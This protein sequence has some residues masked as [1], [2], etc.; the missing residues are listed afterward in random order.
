[1]DT[2]TT[3][4]GSADQTGA[5]RVAE[6][7]ENT[8]FSWDYAKT[9][10]IALKNAWD[11][12]E[13]LK[14]RI[15]RDL[16]S[17]R[18]DSQDERDRGTLEN[19][20]VFTPVRIIDNNIRKE[21]APFIEYM[22]QPGRTAIFV[23]SEQGVDL[24]EREKEFTRVMRYKGWVS[25]FI[26]VQD[27][28]AT[29]GWD[30][31][32]VVFDETK[33]GHIGIDHVRHDELWIP[34][35]TRNIQDCE[36]VVREYMVSVV[37][38]RKLVKTAGFNEELVQKLI[39]A[40]KTTQGGVDSVTLT[41]KRICKVMFKVDGLVYVAWYSPDVLDAWLDGKPRKLYLGRKTGVADAMGN[42]TYDTEASNVYESQYPYFLLFYSETEM[43]DVFQH[44]GRCFLD[45]PKQEAA[46]SML[47]AL[48]NGTTRASNW[49]G[50]V[51]GNATGNA[52]KKVKDLEIE[53]GRIYDQPI[54]FKSLPYPDAAMVRAIEQIVRMNADDTNQVAFAVNARKDSRKSATEINASQEQQAQL[55]GVSLVMQSTFLVE[56]WTYVEGIV[57]SRALANLFPYCRVGKENDTALL[58][59]DVILRP[60]GDVDVVERKERLQA[61]SLAWPLIQNTVL[62]P[63]FLQDMLRLALPG[64][65]ERYAKFLE[66]GDPK[67]QLIQGIAQLVSQL[68]SDPQTGGL[69]PFAQPFA[70]Q[71]Q[72][73]A[74]QVQALLAPPT[75]Q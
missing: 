39:D 32:E 53:N 21:A 20:E 46:S 54:D 3:D 67:A 14:T 40:T 33:P 12:G 56:L 9:K 27:G 62:A 48:V 24:R 70:P 55:S 19:D 34:Q 26:K 60:S 74:Q 52:P 7:P 64:D 31:V 17:V 61:M 49:I 6:T 2:V 75:P 42:I 5:M 23:T 29:H 8:F 10:L 35:D 72:A 45:M 58:S 22:T 30:S 15:R 51:A 36:F 50:T 47:T 66:Q 38:L 25:P 57:N 73:M 28:A 65:G 63:L 13:A 44:V 59:V 37:A 68:V 41:L 71:L 43:P 16:R 69:K 4:G 11:T 1:M 18:I